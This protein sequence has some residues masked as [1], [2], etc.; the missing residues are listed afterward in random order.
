MET[1][2]ENFLRTPVLLDCTTRSFSPQ[3]NQYKTHTQ[4]KHTL[5][6]VN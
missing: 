4:H 5:C 2:H 1:P 6:V 3:Y